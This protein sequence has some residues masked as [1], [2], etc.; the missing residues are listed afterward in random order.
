MNINRYFLRITSQYLFILA[1][2]LSGCSSSKERAS[3]E[4]MQKAEK[5]FSIPSQKD[6]QR[7]ESLYNNPSSVE[8]YLRYTA[9]HNSYYHNK[10]LPDLSSLK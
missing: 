6:V 3:F 1:I 4:V 8:A 9:L 7:P 10:P 2:V 5:A